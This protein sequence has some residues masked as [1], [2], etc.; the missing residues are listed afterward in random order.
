MATERR[1]RFQLEGVEGTGVKIGCGS[2]AVVEEYDFL[3]LSCAG[4]SIHQNI[5]ENATASERDDML[6]RFE[7]ECEMLNRLHHPHIV[8]FLGV[9]FRESSPLPVMLMERL[10]STL[11]ACIECYGKLPYPLG[12]SILYD[13]AIGLRYLHGHIPSPIIH[14]DLTAN[15]VLLTLDMSAKI[16]DLGVAKI[17]NLTPTR[18]VQMTACPGTPS[19]MPP[20]ALVARPIYSTEIDMFAYGNLMTHV[21]CGRWPVPTEVFRTDMSDP[22]SV[23]PLTEVQRREEYLNDIGNTHPLME[24]MRKC[25]S[26]TP[27]ARPNISEVLC[28]IKKMTTEF[29][30][31]LVDKVEFL[32]RI[33]VAASTDNRKEQL[34]LQLHQGGRERKSSNDAD[35]LEAKRLRSM[36]TAMEKRLSI[37]QKEAEADQAIIKANE[38]EIKTVQ[39]IIRAKDQEIALKDQESATKQQQ[40]DNMKSLLTV[41]GEEV[42]SLQEEVSSKDTTLKAKDSTIASLVSQ[43]KQVEGLLQRIQ[44]FSDDN[45]ALNKKIIA[46]CMEQSQSQT[47]S[48]TIIIL[49]CVDCPLYCVVT[50]LSKCKHS[51]GKW[52][53]LKTEKLKTEKLKN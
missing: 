51:V 47:V 3:G 29:P 35:R 20:E 17:L 11:T 9:Y 24:L 1:L 31:S 14:R 16:S 5:F 45:A 48:F 41:E 42:S 39:A 21:F 33:Q 8:Q 36:V 4:K 7:A 23:T 38:Q 44:S 18:M 43:V 30:P 6:E 19:Y 50:S 15:N 40:I 27:K 25:L 22:N 2:Y 26:N 53:T 32:Q 37:K 12:Y 13:V 28:R 49:L 46:T 10:H 34:Q 52:K